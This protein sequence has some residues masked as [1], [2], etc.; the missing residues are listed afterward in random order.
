MFRAMRIF[1]IVS[2]AAITITSCNDAE[3]DIDYREQWVGTY[4]GTKSN[5]SF[6]DTMFT[7]PIS[8]DLVIDENSE[9]SIIVNG[10][11][12]EVTEDGSF[13]P[14]FLDGGSENY[15]L[16]IDGGDLSIERINLGLPGP[17]IQCFILVTKL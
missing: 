1:L 10:V 17:V 3:S 11:L 15:T 14:D 12:L 7:T 13:G 5:T 2:L 4:E 6:E 8:F 9:N 16:R